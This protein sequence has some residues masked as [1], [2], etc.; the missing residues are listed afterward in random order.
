MS[1]PALRARYLAQSIA[2]ASPGQLLV[3]LYDRL[4]VDLTQAEE[5]LRAGDRET[6]SA[7]LMH[8]QEIVAELHST[9]DLS[10]WEGAADLARIYRF[11]LTE[12]IKA[13]VRGDADLAGACRRMV[14]PLRDAWREALQTTQ[15]AAASAAGAVPARVA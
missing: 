4:V 11:L 10:V 3:M 8:A 15:A 13:N 7:R 12:L 6:G 2:T 9:L 1:N 14:E 5:A